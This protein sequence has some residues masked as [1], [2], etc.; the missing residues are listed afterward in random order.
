MKRKF[1]KKI[2]AGLMVTAIALTAAGCSSNESATTGTSDTQTTQTSEETDGQTADSGETIELTFLHTH[3]GS[4][5]EVINQLCEEYTEVTGGKVHVTPIY[6]EGSYEGCLEKLQSMTL[7]NDLPNITQA[8]HHYAYFVTENIPVVYAQDFIDQDGTDVSDFFPK[9][10][11]LGRDAQG[12]L[13]GIPFAVSTSIMYINEDMFEANGLDPVE[14]APTTFEEMQE[15]AKKLTNNGNYGAYLDYAVTGNWEVQTCIEDMGGQMLSE[16]RSEVAFGPQMEELLTILNTM[17]NEDKSMPLMTHEQALEAFKAGKIG[18]YTESTA[19][20]R[21]MQNES[22]CGVTTALHPTDGSGAKGAP[23]GG[24]SLYVLDSTPE[25]EQASWEFV[26][27]M[28]S[29]ET[30]TRVAQNIG[31]MVTRQSA[32]DSEE[33]QNYLVENPAAAVTYEQV[34]WVTPWCNFPGGAGTKYVK[35]VQDGIL[36]V[37]NQQSTPAE[38]AAKMVE[39]CNAIINGGR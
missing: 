29:K 38:A 33:M 17:V 35:V 34:D 13:A 1:L 19:Q 10:L 5:G 11:D 25:E 4:A 12:R 6:A 3:G 8:G 18:M 37:L 24:N 20:L 21:A 27:Y 22:V 31:Y 30:T 9:M 32:L 23:V 36:S 15:V 7:S 2:M 16:D 26:K 28:T 39:D 14:D